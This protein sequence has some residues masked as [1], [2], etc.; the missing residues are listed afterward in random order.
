MKIVVFLCAG[1]VTLLLICVFPRGG[2]AIVPFLELVSTAIV[3][4][5]FPYLFFSFN[6]ILG[7]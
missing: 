6:R 1:V 5:K 2:D 7:I 4:R 3:N